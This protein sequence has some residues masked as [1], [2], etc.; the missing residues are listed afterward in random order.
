MFV[1]CTNFLLLLLLFRLLPCPRSFCWLRSSTTFVRSAAVHARP[2]IN[3]GESRHVYPAAAPVANR[4]LARHRHRLFGYWMAVD[5]VNKCEPKIKRGRRREGW[6]DVGHPLPVN[7]SENN[8]VR[9]QLPSVDHHH[10]RTA[11]HHHRSICVAWVSRI[12]LY[13]YIPTQQI[14]C[15]ACRGNILKLRRTFFSL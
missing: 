13:R 1:L 9:G 8:T 2:V 15:S 14:R 4:L 6:C 10:H 7:W 12:T 11:H 3:H 5:R